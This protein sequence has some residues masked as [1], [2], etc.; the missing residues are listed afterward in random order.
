MTDE[1]LGPLIM[2]SICLFTS[3]AL[4]SGLPAV[5]VAKE[6]WMDV[7]METKRLISSSGIFA[8][9]ILFYFY[10]YSQLLM[11]CMHKKPP[12]YGCMKISG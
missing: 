1:H 6:D 3:H 12:R 5:L 8:A 4:L 11:T 9:N 2:D 10:R 7:E